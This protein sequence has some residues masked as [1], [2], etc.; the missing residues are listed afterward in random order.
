MMIHRQLFLFLFGTFLISQIKPV[1]SCSFAPT[2]Q[3]NSNMMTYRLL[4]RIPDRR[5]GANFVGRVKIIRFEYQDRAAEF[6]DFGLARIIDSPTHPHQVGNAMHI[7]HNWEGCFFSEFSSGDEGVLIGNSM[8][9]YR[10]ILYFTP[11][12][13]TVK[14]GF[15]QIKTDRG[16]L[17]SNIPHP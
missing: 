12:I 16:I 6:P 10:G 14:N 5:Y 11:F 9:T 13:T 17:P 2:E 15:L 3:G 7:I 4:D 1:Y 8:E